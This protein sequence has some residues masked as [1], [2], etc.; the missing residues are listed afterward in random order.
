MVDFIKNIDLSK[1]T[2]IGLG[3]KAKLYCE[4][5]AKDKIA[6]CIKYADEN[7]IPFFILG[8]GS[9]TIFSDEGFDGLVI[10]IN[11]KGIQVH[12]EFKGDV[13]LNAGA[14]EDWDSLVKYCV[15]NGYAGLE[16]LS[17]IPG[18]VGATPIQN[19]G[20]YG[21]EV[22]N[23]ITFVK[24]LDRKTLKSVMFSNEDCLFAYRTSRFKTIDADKYIVTYVMF[25]LKKNGKP[26]IKY[27][28]LENYIGTK[29]DLNTLKEGSER[30]EAVRNAVFEIRKSKSMII[31]SSDTD[32]CSCGS[33]FV[34][35]VLTEG[36]LR[37][38]KSVNSDK[39]IPVFPAG[40]Y[41]KVSAAWLIENSGFKKGYIKNGVGIS[42]KHTL[43]LVN[44]GGTASDL[45]MLADEISAKVYE[46]FGIKLEKETV[47]AGF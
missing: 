35:P 27:K 20:A 19:V 16:C 14:G 38:L 7:K 23:V 25:R 43:A 18:S 36:E 29:L 10:K 46:K 11:I 8:G 32:S 30:L 34:N 44:K 41:F 1:L 39:V 33:F 22:K 9:N 47:L 13:I 12:N 40:P 2:S 42:S 5:D 26:Y 24:T 6:E 31:D 15:K 28:E 37:N 17:G 21:Q 3:G 4:C 45:L